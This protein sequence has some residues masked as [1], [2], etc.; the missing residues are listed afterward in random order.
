[1]TTIGELFFNIRAPKQANM[2]ADLMS[3]LF[4]GPPPAASSASRPAL[5][6]GAPQPAI[7]EM[8]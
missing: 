6:Q 4:S 2:L 8:D 7:E 5:G 3:S 1:M